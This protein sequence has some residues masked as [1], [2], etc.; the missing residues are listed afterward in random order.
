MS[1]RTFA[2]P[3][4]PVIPANISPAST[5]ADRPKKAGALVL[6]ILSCAC[7]GE[8]IAR[9]R[10]KTKGLVEFPI[11]KQPGVQSHHRSTKLK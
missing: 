7:V 2:I 11:S 9:H 8:N 3:H 5:N 4:K 10:G 1:R 6:A